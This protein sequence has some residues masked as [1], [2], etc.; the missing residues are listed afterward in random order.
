MLLEMKNITKTYGNLVANDNISLDLKEGEV[1]SIV[2]EN[3]AGKTTIMK[4]LYGMEE[5][6]SGN[7]YI[8]GKEVSIKSPLDA[9][10]LGI[11]MIQQHFMLF[12]PFKVFENIVYGDEPKNGLFFDRKKAKKHVEELSEKYGL[13]ID[14]D[15]KVSDLPVGIQQR[16]EIL[17]V[18]YQDAKIIIFDEPTAVLTPQEVK[19]LL[20]TIKKLAKMGKSI[21]LIT[22]KLNEVME[23]SNR[24]FVMRSGKYIDTLKKEDTSVEEISYLMV[25]KHIPERK[26]NKQ[27]RKDLVLK[28]DNINLE[29][30][31][32]VLIDN[33]SMEIYGGEI[34]GI[35][36]VS[37]NGQSELIEV[38]TGLRKVD[39]GKIILNGK[40]IQNLSVDK[41]RDSSLAVIPED[42]Y[43]FGCAKDAD[44]V[45]T[46]IMSHHRKEEFSKSGIL[47]NNKIKEFSK[48]ILNKYDVRYSN[49]NQKAGE[50]SG[51]NL[52]KLIVAREMEENSRLLIAAEPT[53]GVD[54]GAIEDIHDKLID[55]RNKMDAILLIS[56]ELTEI[57]ALSDRIYTIYKGKFNGHFTRE[58]A[59]SDNIGLKMMGGYKD[60]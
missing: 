29:K 33:L 39:S 54:I 27:D 49:L 32:E 48:K 51:G 41:I 34:V 26:V 35:A 52:Q 56:S 18:L 60:E 24:I 21:I 59:S 42:R 37:G 47:K 44:L 13:H 55:K 16:I 30:N 58:E 7:I 53:R 15:Q 12:P 1:L 3:G 25:G 45:E 57:L 46:A 10:N 23:V 36:G 14:K 22:H 20:E 2:G 4:I 50:L 40:E 8:N 6:D 38:V 11:G 9:I 19:D 43:F 17:K 31:G 5:K 28:I